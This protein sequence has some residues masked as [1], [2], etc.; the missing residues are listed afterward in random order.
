MKKNNKKGIWY[1]KDKQIT[2][3]KPSGGGGSGGSGGGWRLAVA[4]NCDY[5]AYSAQLHWDLG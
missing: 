2:Q 1:V 4:V 5:I 3:Q